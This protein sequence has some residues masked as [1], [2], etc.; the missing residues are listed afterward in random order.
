MITKETFVKTMERLETLDKKMDA[1]DD[2]MRKLS[3]DFCGFYIPDVFDI[4][5]DTLEEA[6]GD[7]HKW[8][9]YCVYEENWLEDFKLGDVTIMREGNEE[10]IDLSTWDKVYDF[11][12]W[13]NEHVE[14]DEDAFKMV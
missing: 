3:P 5:I 10:N 4:T 9:G 6:M 2:A 11:I 1:I 14:G 7:K 12:V 8:I 13:E